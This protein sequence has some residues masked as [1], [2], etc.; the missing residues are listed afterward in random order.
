VSAI[1]LH[2]KNFI[3][4]FKAT[5]RDYSMPADLFELEITESSA[6]QDIEESVA[7]MKRLAL[8]GVNFSLDDFGTGYSSLSYLKRLPV[9]KIKID[10]SFIQDLIID[11]NDQ[12]LVTAII[13]I[14]RHLNL[15]IVAEGVE[16]QAQLDWLKQHKMMYQGYLFSKPIKQQDFYQL[17]MENLAEKLNQSSLDAPEQD[18]S[19]HT[20]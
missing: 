2:S 16:W 8:I 5:L 10:R 6:I 1:E 20:P 9:N 17:L 13:S 7:K 3:E 12:A 19:S 15:S 11:H 4:T 14:G 18:Q